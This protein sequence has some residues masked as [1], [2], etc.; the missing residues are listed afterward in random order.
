MELHLDIRMG[1][2][3]IR[4]AAPRLQHKLTWRQVYEYYCISNFYDGHWLR[5]EVL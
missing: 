2:L 4:S 1:L 3:R 5:T